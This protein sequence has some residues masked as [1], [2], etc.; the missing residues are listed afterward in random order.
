LGQ[1]KSKRT[2]RVFF[3]SR[4]WSN[5]SVFLWILLGV[6]Y[7]TA[8][9]VLGFATL[10]KGHSSLFWFGSYCRDLVC[11][12]NLRV[13]EGGSVR[14]RLADVDGGIRCAVEVEG[15]GAALDAFPVKDDFIALSD[16][17]AGMGGTVRVA[18]GAQG[19]VRII[20]ELP[21]QVAP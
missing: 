18:P 20:A 12:A 7:V 9:F 14:I 2:R 1:R 8:L 13:G 3:A 6:L 4:K 19:G 17:I 11:L 10:R 16:P 21:A 15:A 5:M